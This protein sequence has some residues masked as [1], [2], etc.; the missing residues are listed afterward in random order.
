MA[1]LARQ[2][3][4]DSDEYYGARLPGELCFV[5]ATCTVVT[6]EDGAFSCRT[7]WG[8]RMMPSAMRERPAVR[9]TDSG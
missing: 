4:L 6:W 1:G 3:R 8:F 7:G 2:G 9:T 5:S